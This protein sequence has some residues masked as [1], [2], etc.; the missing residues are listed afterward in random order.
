MT[1]AFD[2]ALETALRAV[3]TDTDTEDLLHPFW[4]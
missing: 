2:L 3:R 1:I 4:D